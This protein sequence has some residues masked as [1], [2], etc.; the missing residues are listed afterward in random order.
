MNQIYVKEYKSTDES[1]PFKE[2]TDLIHDSFKEHTKAG[3][4]FT[5]ANITIPE[6]KEKMT[7]GYVYIAYDNNKP[8]GLEILSITGSSGYHALCAMAPAY[9]RK[10]VMQMLFAN[11]LKKSNELKLSYLLSDTAFEAKCS[12]QWHLK[13][14]FK[15]FSVGSLETT[16]YYSYVFKY[17]LRKDNI[18][19]SNIFIYCH[20]I[21]KYCLC[22]TLKTK[23][24]KDRF[25]S[26][27]KMIRRVRK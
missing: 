20:F 13:V 24:G 16:N 17:P 5:C 22:K 4:N 23:N 7:N 10:G 19:N 9:K 1:I 21:I 11:V 6:L 26:I 12:V 27:S 15:K 14:G 2:L 3:I 25:P 18:R 8:I